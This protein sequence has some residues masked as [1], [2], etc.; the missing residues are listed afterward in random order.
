MRVARAHDAR[1][2]TYGREILKCSKWPDSCSPLFRNRFWA[3]LSFDARARA[4]YDARA[5]NNECICWPLTWN[6]CVPNLVDLWW[7]VMKLLMIMWNHKMASWWRHGWVI[8]LKRLMC[9]FL[10]RGKI[11][12]KFE[13]DS[14]RSFWDNL[15]TKFE[16]KVFGEGEDS[17][18]NNMWYAMILHIT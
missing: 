14:G 15:R 17:Y 3:F 2:D 4:R 9:R 11:L 18:N 13:D 16:Q 8:T 12:W 10:I 5:E 6:V 7:L 1:T